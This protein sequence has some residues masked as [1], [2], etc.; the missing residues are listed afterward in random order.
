M[1]ERLGTTVDA[2]RLIHICFEKEDRKKG[3]EHPI[4]LVKF[5]KRRGKEVGRLWLNERNPKYTLDIVTHTVFFKSSKNVI[6]ALKFD[7]TQ[8]FQ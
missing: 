8:V 1:A 6:Q 2:E 4:G 7:T 5:D 3:D